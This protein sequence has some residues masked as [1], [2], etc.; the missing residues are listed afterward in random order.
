MRSDRYFNWHAILDEVRD[1]PAADPR[2]R[3]RLALA[4]FFALL[5][6]VFGRIVQ[7]EGSQGAAFRQQAAAP[8]A[9]EQLVPGVRGRI[10]AA[11]GA[12]LAVDKETRGLAVHYRWI[13]EPA[14]AEWLRW[15]ARQRLDR[16]ARGDPQRLA[17]AEAE[18]LAERRAM[19]ERIIRLAGTSP[20]QWSADARRITARVKHIRDSVNRRRRE[21]FDASKTA[22]RAAGSF[23]SRAKGWL[24]AIVEGA[25]EPR[26]FTPIEVAEE[27]EYHVMI[28]DVPVEVMAEIESHPSA[29]PAVRLVARRQRSYPRGALAAHVLGHLG[30]MEPGECAEG[31]DPRGW[32]GRMGLEQ[33]RE[34]ALRAMPGVAVELADRSGRVLSTYRRREPTVGRDLLL[35]LDADLQ[36]TA[37]ALLEQALARRRARLPGARAAGGAA[38]VM[39]VQTGAV[40]VAAS[41]PGFDPNLFVAG[42]SAAVEGLLRAEN[43]PLF[44][45]AVRM[46]IPPGSVFKIITAA[47]LLDSG[48]IHPGERFHCRGYLRSPDRLRCAVYQR[49]GVG[50][51][52]V[53]LADALSA[54]CNVYFLHHAG[55]L[56]W[57]AIAD[58]A[59]R[60][61][62][63]RPT[64]IDLP[65]EASGRLPMPR[66]VPEGETDRWAELPAIGQGDLDATPIQIARMIAAVANGGKLVTPHLVR[67]YGLAALDEPTPAW[68][69]LSDA[70]RDAPP[71]QPIEGLTPGLLAAIRE[72]LRRAVAEPAGT[73][74]DGDDSLQ[75][76]WAGKTGTA[77]TGVEDQEHAWF[78]GYAPADRPRFCLVVVLERSGNAADSAVPVAKR[79]VVRMRQLGRI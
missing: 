14:D 34:A 73:A 18:V 52:E 25:A 26:R 63:G 10:L 56:G 50:H 20:G 1:G 23:L 3:V 57:A 27:Y 31:G 8:L 79:L 2:H 37:E 70:S 78:A 55:R 32:V 38:V 16:S 62:L 76:R 72:G 42:D 48:T 33:A 53:A 46:A 58:W 7:L 71:P 11:N 15:M 68:Q 9:R 36:E 75:V 44:N 40:L 67:G 30:R 66:P 6:V 21:A 22:R 24:L 35:T 64:G 17:A 4:A 12:V 41:A 29:Y 61:G 5:Q 69:D 60:F 47:A 54:S 77:E 65:G 39:D 43:D 13:E 45:R 49:H 59:W 74:Y 28:S 51:G 19:A